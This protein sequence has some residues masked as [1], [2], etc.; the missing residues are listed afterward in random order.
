VG[1]KKAE[2][3]LRQFLRIFLAAL[4]LI[5]DGKKKRV[6]GCRHSIREKKIANFLSERG[7]EKGFPK[8]DLETEMP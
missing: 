1:W 6:S 2:L 3:K 8:R 7:D 4:S 5:H